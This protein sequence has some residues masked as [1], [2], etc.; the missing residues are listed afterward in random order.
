MRDAF[1]KTA[2]LFWF[3][4]SNVLLK[5]QPSWCKMLL[6]AIPWI[7]SSTCQFRVNRTTF[8]S[9]HRHRCQ[10]LAWCNRRHQTQLH[11]QSSARQWTISHLHNQFLSLQTVFSFVGDSSPVSELSTCSVEWVFRSTGCWRQSGAYQTLI[12][13][14][15]R[16][17]TSTMP[18][19][20]A[21]K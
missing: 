8:V 17:L 20:L 7:F 2:L 4:M 15:F 1:I 5:S 12:K 18:C 11:S 16:R 10:L 21:N 19:V 14:I 9:Q 6:S 3:S 13:W